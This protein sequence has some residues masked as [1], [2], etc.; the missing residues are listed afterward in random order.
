[1]TSRNSEIDRRRIPK[2]EM[3]FSFLSAVCTSQFGKNRQIALVFQSAC[4]RLYQWE[5]KEK[6]RKNW[7]C[8]VV[9]V[10]VSV[11]A[12]LFLSQM[13]ESALGQP[14]GFAVATPPQVVIQHQPE[15]LKCYV[16]CRP[17]PMPGGA[18]SQILVITVVDTEAKKIAVYHQDM[19][20]GAVTW[21]STRNIQP[22]LM[23]DQF[24]ARSPW[25]SD[26]KQEVL[27]LGETNTFN[28]I[29]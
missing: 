11:T 18:P 14:G 24:N 26:V 15:L 28:V 17:L 9:L 10:G 20:N 7:I 4:A 22:D 13:W 1:M 23:I 5:R 21:L 2:I 27:R 16:D 12:G 3:G 29:K 8:T 6:K 19:T 25:P